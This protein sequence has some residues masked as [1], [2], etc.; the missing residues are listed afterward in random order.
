LQAPAP[1]PIELDSPIF[2][3]RDDS[4]GFQFEPELSLDENGLADGPDEL[5]RRGNASGSSHP[6]G[7]ARFLERRPARLAALCAM[8]A[9]LLLGVISFAVMRSVGQFRNPALRN[10]VPSNP[11]REIAPSPEPS[12]EHIAAASPPEETAEPA[13][14]KAPIAVPKDAPAPRPDAT[15]LDVPARPS[16]P[17]S[18]TSRAKVAKA[19]TFKVATIFSKHIGPVLAIAVTR[20]GEIALTAGAD[21]TARLWR[22]STGTEIFALP[23]H[24][25][26]ILDAAMTPDG[27]FALTVTRG[28]ANT[29]GAVRLWNLQT[30]QL[31]FIG[32]SDSQ[33]GPMQAVAFVQRDR[34]LTAGQEGRAIL[35]DLRSGKP[36][37]ALG[38]QKASVRA[39]AMA[40][41]PNGR[42]AVTG[43]EDGIVHVWNLNTRVQTGQWN[44]HEGPVSN[45]SI[46]ADGRRVATA[47]QDRTVILW[48]A[49]HGSQIKRFTMPGVDRPKCVAILPDGNVLAAGGLVG[50]VVLWNAQTGAILRRSQPPHTAHSDLA[51]LPSDGRRILTADQDGFVRIWT[52]REP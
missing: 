21:H 14:D 31:V 36:I 50:H 48:D 13:T 22:V 23:P 27:Q 15:A 28:K 32:R 26:A 8:A 29:N 40:V 49:E 19:P 1:P 18:D 25:T 46:S 52:A 4:G 17:A 47:S 34:A 30:R 20:D 2:I 9:L 44:G 35:W 45:I 24:P 12:D 42:R 41:F 33:V 37:G 38:T 7:A 6:A 5:S 3:V 51:V 10:P 43:G 39:H 11:P 16:K